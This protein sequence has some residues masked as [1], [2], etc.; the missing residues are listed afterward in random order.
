MGQ[1]SFIQII[2]K[3]ITC[4]NEVYYK[5]PFTFAVQPAYPLPLKGCLASDCHSGIEPIREHHSGMAKDIYSPGKEKGDPNGCVVCHF[6][7]PD[8]L[9]SEKAHQGIVRYP[10]SMWVNEQTCGECHS[11]H[12]YAMNRNL[13]QTE[14]GKIQGAVWG[15][16]AL[17]GYKSIYGN[18]GLDDPDGKIPLFGNED[19]KTYMEKLESTHP[20]AFPDSLLELP[21]VDLATLH[22]HPEQ[23]VFTYIRSDCQRCHVG[24]RG[25]QRR[26]DYHGLGCAACH[27]P[28]SDEGF[29]EGLDQSIPPDA[30]GKMLVHS[31][32]SSRKAK[33]TVNGITWSGIPGE[34]CSTCHNRGKRIGVSY[35]GMIESAYDTPWELPPGFGDEFGIET[36][37]QPRGV[38]AALLDIQA[39]FSTV[40]EAEDGYLLT[41]RGNPMGNVIRRKD[42]VIVHSAG[43]ADFRVP[44]LKNLAA[45]NRWK[46]PEKATT[47]MIG[48]KRHMEKL[49]CYSCHSGW[50][51]Q[52]YG[53][54]VKVDYS[55]D[56]RSVDWIASGK[57]HE[58]NRETAETSRDR[59]PVSLPGKITEGRTYIRWENPALG[60]NGEGRVGPIIPGC[61]QITTVIG[62]DG[63]P[64]FTNKIWRTP[65][66]ME[67]SGPDGQ[68][69]IDMTPAQ[70]HTVTAEAR[71]CVSCHADPKELDFECCW[72]FQ[73]ASSFINGNILKKSKEDHTVFLVEK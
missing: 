49:E 24:V 1:C 53:C 50:A 25:A 36:G 22:E 70:P 56:F 7:D 43:G 42:E 64:M 48:V 60:I 14:A 35:L 11:E 13:M 54:H 47:A 21:E 55:K 2:I 38:A 9:T 3:H 30:K 32:Q 15:W 73:Y 57:L 51:A 58:A 39:R 67:G 29:Y 20:Y 63:K 46:H 4:H 66:G 6:G 68:K 72:V 28:Y 26:G 34:M 44:V 8:A 71:E 59:S 31:I 52:C 5:K 62:Q 10:A 61:Q 12:I 33:V 65:G 41:A 23:A 19:Y 45:G 69:G 17:A 16:G 37:G 27:I 40:Y 18:Y